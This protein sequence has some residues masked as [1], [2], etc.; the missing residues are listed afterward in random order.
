MTER[1]KPINERARWRM[2]YDLFR[3]SQTGEIVTYEQMGSALGLDPVIHRHQLQ[4]AARR[5]GL[6]LEKVDKRAVDA[7]QGVGYRI[8]EPTEIL[9]LGRRR[10]RKAGTQIDRGAIVT[11]AVDLNLIDQQNRNALEMLA[12]GFAVQAEIN[13]RVLT[14]Q[15]EHADLL[16]MLL[17][18]VDR[19]EGK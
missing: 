11:Q 17:K 3:Q 2:I 16:D 6:E 15:Q 1:F 18:R 19:L 9:G 12:R 4:M 13:K 7:K 10:N 8:V 5:A 14:R